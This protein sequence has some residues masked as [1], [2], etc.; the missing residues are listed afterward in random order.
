MEL[1]ILSAVC[2]VYQPDSDPRLHS[3]VLGLQRDTK[4]GDAS[5]SG[6]FSVLSARALPAHYSGTAR[7]LLANGASAS[8]FML[9]T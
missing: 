3:F 8:G 9:K 1:G 4:L 5:F 6:F 2:G 7:P